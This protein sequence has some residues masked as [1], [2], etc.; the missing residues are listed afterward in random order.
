MLKDKTKIV[1][2]GESRA[3]LIPADIIKDSAFPFTEGEEL[4]I[5]ILP[6]GNI[7]IKR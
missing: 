6:E 4:E 5:E 1:K 7:I 3:F 2:Y